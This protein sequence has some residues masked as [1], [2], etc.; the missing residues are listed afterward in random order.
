M[1]GGDGLTDEVSNNNPLVSVVINCY[2]GER[3]LRDAIDSI[4]GQTY[5]NWEIIFVDNAS[6]D[7]SAQI[8]LSYDN[9]VKYIILNNTIP[10]YSARNKALEKCAGKYVAFL[11]CD[12]VWFPEKLSVQVKQ[13]VKGVDVVFSGFKVINSDG[14]VLNDG[15][16]IPDG[17]INTNSLFRRNI[18]SIS[19]V[20][21]KK[22][23]FLNNKFDERFNLVGDF[24]FWVRLSLSHIFS[25]CKEILQYS[26]VHEENM[27]IVKIDEWCTERRM[28]YSSFINEFRF[29]K[30]PWFLLYVI[31]N[32]IRVVYFW[33]RR[34]MGFKTKSV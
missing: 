12:D 22:E 21:I 28:M 11:D 7:S 18:I 19:S 1:I 13:I 32:E 24:D 20:M 2:N 25:G 5:R 27:S 34:N 23:L 16:V 30:V 17:V 10:L 8:A 31:K 9:R 4:Y 3:F 26:R 14:A 29:F 33:V 6:T 15:V